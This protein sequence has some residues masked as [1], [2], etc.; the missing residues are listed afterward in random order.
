MVSDV[1]GFHP[2][3]RRHHVLLFLGLISHQSY[4]A[5]NSGEGLEQST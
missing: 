3:M 5:L 4:E 2:A 1:Q